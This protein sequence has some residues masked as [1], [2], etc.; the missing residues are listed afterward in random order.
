[1]NLLGLKLKEFL[2]FNICIKN[3][4]ETK[5][6]CSSWLTT[7]ENMVLGNMMSDLCS[8]SKKVRQAF[9]KRFYMMRF[10][11]K[12]YEILKELQKDADFL[13]LKI[14]VEYLNKEFTHPRLL[15]KS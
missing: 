11:R 15:N 6:T 13:G 3:I 12:N 1:M 4:E 10:I 14:N 9:Y 2:D 7:T 8:Q 5:A